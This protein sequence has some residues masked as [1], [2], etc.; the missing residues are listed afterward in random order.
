MWVYFTQGLLLGVYA[1]LSP[2]PFQFFLI[3]QTLRT[4]WKRTLPAAVAPLLSDA[5]AV[6]LSLLALSQL[7]GWFLNGLRVGGGLFILYMAYGAVLEFRRL[8]DAPT[9]PPA[10]NQPLARAFV[11]NF[12]NPNV[13]IFWTTIGAPIV[14]DG[15]KQ[16]AWHGWSFI[17]GMYG[18]LIPATAGLIILFGTAG[19]LKPAVRR[20][21]QLGLALVLSLLA[22]YQIV[23]GITGLLAL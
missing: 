4:G 13:Y 23:S 21:I 16:S 17:G 22:L 12:L 1:A 19:G 7:P 18:A 20:W 11:M 10:G 2:G 15:W 3:S 9:A 8:A 5:P 14:L 6:T